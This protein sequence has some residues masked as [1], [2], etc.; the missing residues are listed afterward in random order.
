MYIV[1][2]VTAETLP[3][4]FAVFVKYRLMAGNAD[5]LA[6]L[7][8]KLVVALRILIEGPQYPITGV[9]VLSAVFAEASLT[10]IVLIG[11][12][13]YSISIPLNLPP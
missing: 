8:F 13:R 7:G 5:Q 11:R 2:P 10:G 1:A 9:V 3:G 12:A 4:Q 6:V